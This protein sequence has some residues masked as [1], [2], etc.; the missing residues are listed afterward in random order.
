[1]PK[2][3]T[4]NYQR[5]SGTCDDDDDE[6]QAIELM[7]P[8]SLDHSLQTTPPAT[9]QLATMPKRCNVEEGEVRINL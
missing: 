5:E 9:Q 7:K 1:M 4:G 8:P 6:F 3:E 2:L